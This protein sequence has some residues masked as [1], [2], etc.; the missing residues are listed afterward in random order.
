MGRK[1]ANPSTAE[2][3]PRSARGDAAP[4]PD[5]MTSGPSWRPGRAIIG[6]VRI[7]R[8]LPAVTL[9]GLTLAATCLIFPPVGWW[10]LAY[11]C[12]VPW[13]ICI[14]TVRRARFV[15]GVSYL[16]GLGYFLIN[17]HWM[18]PVT[19]P[20]YVVMCLYF[21]IYFPLAA[22]PIRH[23]YRRR[24]V[25]VALSAP[26]AWVAIEYLRSISTLGFPFILLAHSQYKVL[27]VIQISD[28]VGA[29][30]VSFVLAM[31]N[32]ALTDLFIQPL[33]TARG[34]PPAR[35]I[36]LPVGSLA[37][38]LVLIATV[39][40]GVVRQS[41][42]YFKPGA[43]VAVVQGDF[44]MYVDERGRRTPHDVVFDAYL[45]LARQAAAEKP[46]LVV[47]PETAW[48][49]FINDEFVNATP[50]DL[51]E[52]RSRRFPKY[53]SADIAYVQ[54]I[55]RQRRDAFQRLSTDS[56]VPIV[57]GSSSL[58]WQPT[59]I[60]PRVDGYN[61]AFLVKPGMEH[62]AG[63]YDKIH[64]VLFGEYVPFRYTPYHSVYEFLNARTPWGRQGMEYSLTAGNRFEVLEFPVASQNGQTCRA[65]VPI[66]YEEVMPYIPRTFVTGTDHAPNGKNIDILLSISNDG[67]FHHT[68]E[69]EQHL[70]AAVF[71]AIEN[72]IPVARSVNTGTS[73]LVDPNGHIHH[74]VSLSVDKI[75][76]L[77]KVTEALQRLETTSRKLVGTHTPPAAPTN[78]LTR[79]LAAYLDV[80]TTDL[81]PALDAVGPEFT[82][83]HRRLLFLANQYRGASS[84]HHDEAAYL[85]QSQI[86]DD[87]ETVRRW[88][89][90]PWTAPGFSVGR[91]RVDNRVTFYTRFGDRFSQV[92]LA[93]TLMI[94]LDW[95]VHR[96]RRRPTS[97]T[98]QENKNEH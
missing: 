18:A 91:L 96:L 46:D 21:A 64:L 58:E 70:C 42:K 85:L 76:R 66:C 87:L 54:K 2:K 72:R 28:L 1:R 92:A 19:P 97:L 88:Q 61:S 69:L 65:G 89:A 27:T 9:S 78:N 53:E 6:Q 13:F 90:R 59:G 73:A 20:G 83:I 29:Y 81:R 10:P 95:L 41:R 68:S 98:D 80:C 60:P 49:G 3:R 47:L 74:R 37:T 26:V 14:C 93:L 84:E 43:R 25:S 86:A 35:A 16:L 45:G 48:L 23:L 52:I 75:A 55:S 63:R 33:K 11:V 31:V 5:T 62:P 15:Y 17:C 44:A 79:A 40:Y 32:G 56:A 30:G 8:R 24:G 34:E 36:R 77:A 67:W 71:R 12:L 50:E 82:F 22:W 7:E 57:L 94:I 38:A 51:E 39:L 4:A